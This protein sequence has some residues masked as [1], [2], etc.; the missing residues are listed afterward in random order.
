MVAYKSVV[1]LL[2]ASSSA[3]FIAMWSSLPGTGA[4]CL[5]VG[6]DD[7]YDAGESL[8]SYAGLEIGGPFLAP[9]PRELFLD[10]QAVETC[11]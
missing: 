2:V 11:C 3:C 5:K 8:C 7:P 4:V 9:L 1:A 6:A 10:W